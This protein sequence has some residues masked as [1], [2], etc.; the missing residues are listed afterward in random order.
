MGKFP[1][2]MIILASYLLFHQT[3]EAVNGARCFGSLDSNSSYAQN[4]RDLFSTLAN[5]V[6][7]NGGFYNA[8]LGQYP[9]TVYALGFC[10]KYYE[11]KAC[12]RC[13]ESLALD[14]ET[15]CGNITKSFVWSSD[16][17]DRFWCLIRS[18]NQPFG[19]LELIPP[20]IEADPDHI[21]PSKDMTLFM[22]QWESAVNKTLETATQANTSSVHKYYSA[23]HAHFTEFPNVNMAMQCTPDITSQD[24][25][26]CLGDCVEYFREQF[27]GRA[28][29]MASFPSCLFRWDNVTSMPALPRPPA[30][31]KRPSYIPEK[32]GQINSC[33]AVKLFC[34]IKNSI[35]ILRAIKS[36]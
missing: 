27:R 35:Y 12:L 8:S 1:A 11:Q 36:N 34:M 19:N 15:S 2:L 25:K 22:Q 33:S 6:V 14:T 28:G 30:Q 24:C 13:L 23:I 9:N 20:L 5:D 21:E 18:S 32:K 26:Q 7:T 3:L 16:D 31:E 10:E 29:G 4:R 17:E